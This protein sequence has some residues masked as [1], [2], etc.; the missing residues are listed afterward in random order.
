MKNSPLLFQSEMEAFKLRNL[1]FQRG[2][3]L[4]VLWMH[5][6]SVI[7]AEIESVKKLFSFSLTK[8]GMG[9]IDGRIY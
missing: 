7:V 9:A 4:E 2:R 8:S 6:C 3:I 1:H 5:V